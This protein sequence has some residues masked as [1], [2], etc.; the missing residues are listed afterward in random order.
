MRV[1]GRLI[2]PRMKPVNMA[3]AGA[4]GALAVAITGALA[5]C[6]G[7]SVDSM[8]PW[9]GPVER[10]RTLPADA[11]VYSCSNARELVVRQP[12]GSR[13]VMIVFRE[14]EFRLDQA[15]A[16]PAR[17]TNGST[18]LQANGGEVSLEEEGKVT[19]ANCRRAA[20]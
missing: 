17:Y 6:G 7:F 15:P 4:G 12:A 19:Y 18:T 20:G 8:N 11:T 3:K 10:G 1:T 16:D 5:G 14:R 2:I 9:S 13:S